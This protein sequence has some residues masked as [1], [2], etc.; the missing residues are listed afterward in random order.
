M[1]HSNYVETCPTCGGSGR[2]PA[3]PTNPMA[4]RLYD[5]F[6]ERELSQK[7]VAKLLGRSQATVSYWLA[8]KRSPSAADLCQIADLFNTTTDYIVGRTNAR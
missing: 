5:L 2:I 1:P 4:R 8:G 6:R 7:A 3:P